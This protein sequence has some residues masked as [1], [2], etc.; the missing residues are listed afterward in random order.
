MKSIVKLE[1]QGVAAE[2]QVVGDANVGPQMITID[3]F[4]NLTAEQ[5]NKITNIYIFID[6]ENNDANTGELEIHWFAFEKN[7]Q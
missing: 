1:G 2:A 3:Q 4:A 7:A 5:K 6:Y